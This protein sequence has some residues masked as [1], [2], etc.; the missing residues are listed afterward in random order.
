ML[1]RSLP[2]LEVD[3]LKMLGSIRITLHA[4]QHL[5][6][7]VHA[8][9]VENI[10]PHAVVTSGQRLPLRLLRQH[11][12]DH[13]VCSGKRIAIRRTKSSRRKQQKESAEDVLRSHSQN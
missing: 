11:A 6:V 10:S 9:V 7:F 5:R 1:V 3:N 2:T 13:R 8:F 12:G 4:Y